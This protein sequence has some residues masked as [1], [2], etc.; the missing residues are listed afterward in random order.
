LVAGL[1][2]LAVVVLMLKPVEASFGDDPLL[3]LQSF[4]RPLGSVATRVD[5]GTVTSSLGRRSPA[6]SVY[7]IARDDACHRA[8]YRRLVAAVGAASVVVVLTL[9]LLVASSAGVAPPAWTG[10]QRPRRDRRTPPPAETAIS[11]EDEAP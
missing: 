4:D 2:L 9:V 1:G 7:S 11:S 5:C 8:G 10:A 3:R 6:A